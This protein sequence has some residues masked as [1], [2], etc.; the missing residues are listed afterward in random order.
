MDIKTKSFASLPA[1][2][3]VASIATGLLFISIPLLTKISTITGESEKVP[4]VLIKQWKPL[5]PP[6]PEQ[7][8]KLEEQKRLEPT[9]KDPPREKMQH[10][11]INLAANS[12]TSGMTGTIQINN[13]LN[14]DI[15]VTDSRFA[16]AYN[17]D[18]VDRRPRTLKTFQ[19][20][21]PF[22]AQQKGIEGRIVVRLVVDSTG[23]PQEPEIAEVEPK[24]AEG[25]FDEAALAGIMKFKFSPAMKG[26]KP[27]DCI[28]RIPFTF[29][30]TE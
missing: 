2:F 5:P 22:E 21:Y 7:E 23:M 20:R 1:S 11:R 29:S 26:G 16:S 6:E 13:I 10:P 18:E 9:K 25:L 24:E 27:V 17:F 3:L 14:Q 30:V 8:K 19:P 15:K 4:P 12:L 28:V